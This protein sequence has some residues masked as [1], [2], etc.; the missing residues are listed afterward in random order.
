[1]RK[2]CDY[3]TLFSQWCYLY[4]CYYSLL[5]SHAKTTNISD[6]FENYVTD[7]SKFFHNAFQCHLQ[8]FNRI[9]SYK[10]W[11]LIWLLYRI[12]KIYWS[13]WLRH[14]TF[15]KFSNILKAKWIISR[16]NNM[17]NIEILSWY[18]SLNVFN[19]CCYLFPIL[20][21]GNK[22]AFFTIT[23]INVLHDTSSEHLENW[24][25]TTDKHTSLIIHQWM[26]VQSGP[27][28][29]R[30]LMNSCRRDTLY[31]METASTHTEL[32]PG[33]AVNQQPR[34]A[35]CMPTTPPADSRLDATWVQTPDWDFKVRAE[36]NLNVK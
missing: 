6:F 18:Q 11:P 9:F 31:I 3:V 2:I 17:V 10:L 23:C 19:C 36:A 25:E 16:S 30:P 8:C 13:S 28:A 1:M 20:Y 22:A 21:K 12:S 26:V 35:P 32:I 5:H 27:H 7:G 33:S 24:C 15:S 14:V 34:G 29:A 4:S